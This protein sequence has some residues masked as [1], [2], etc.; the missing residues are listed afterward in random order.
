MKIITHRLSLPTLTLLALSIFLSPPIQSQNLG[1]PHKIKDY[2]NL[3]HEEILTV[4][5]ERDGYTEGTLRAAIIGANG[6]RSQTPYTTVKI[7][8][9]PHVRRIQITK[10]ALPS[11]EGS[12]ITLNCLNGSGKVLIEKINEEPLADAK[13]SK[14]SEESANPGHVLRIISNNNT[15]RSCHF[16]GGL[17]A[18]LAIFGNHNIIEHNTLGYL[19]DH[20]AKHLGA[21]LLRGTPQGNQGPGL[22]IGEGSHDNLVQHN[23]IL[24][25]NASG[26][27]LGPGVGAGNEIR[28]NY[29]SKNQGSPIQSSPSPWQIQSPSIERITLIKDQTNEATWKITG[30]RPAQSRVQLYTSNPTEAEINTLIAEYDGRG[31][32]RATQFEIEVAQNALPENTPALSALAFKKNFNTSEFS[33]PAPIPGANANTQSKTNTPSIFSN[34]T[35]PKTTAPKRLPPAEPTVIDLFKDGRGP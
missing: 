25:N 31:A 34:P 3:F 24:G 9:T 30:T 20:S 2:T 32:K 7:N 8:M 23:E 26:I 6:L 5:T 12:L 29:F 27:K 16:T 35:P 19:K 17:G 11:L 33:R 13:A 22:F 28:Y 4:T 10:G 18:G 15:I 1:S 21:A 14:E